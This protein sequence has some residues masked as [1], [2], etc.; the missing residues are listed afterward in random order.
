[1]MKSGENIFLTGAAG[2]GKTYVLNEF[3]LGAKKRELEVAVTAS[4]GIAATHMQGMTIHSWSGIGI[5][6]ALPE[7]ELKRMQNNPALV[8]RYKRTDVLIIDEVSMISAELLD[9]IDKAARYLRENDWPFGG[10]QVILCGDFFQLPPVSRE[11]Q[12]R[13]AFDAQSWQQAGLHIC[14]LEKNYRQSDTTLEAIL[15]AMR[16]NTVS[17]HMIDR[18][19][20]C[21][22]TSVDDLYR[23]TKLFTHNVD[24]DKMNL[25]HLE[26]LETEERSYAMTSKGEKS[27]VQSIKKGCLAPEELR[28]RIGAVVMFVKNNFAQGYVNGTIG[29]VVDFGDDNFPIVQLATGKEVTVYPESWALQDGETILGEIA[30][31]P[32]RLAWAMTVHKSQGMSL[33]AA[34]IDLRK[35]FLPGMGYVALSRVR[36]LDGLALRG[37]NK[38]AFA[39][40]ERVLAFDR[41]ISQD[42]NL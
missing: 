20:E 41:Q 7:T 9:L 8:Q 3:I 25:M 13:F 35:C 36:S 12:A 30:Q 6:Q 5:K 33:D 32:L 28:V 40:N 42:A 37:M 29:E 39:V 16:R 17:Q 19:L 23:P 31:V 11:R 27:W 1:M 21:Q 14:Y 4:T 10:M 22:E 26:D 18:L 38:M 15:S 2:S 24:V 34:E